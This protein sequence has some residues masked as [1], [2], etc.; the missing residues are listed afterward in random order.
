MAPEG[1]R[2]AAST[3]RLNRLRRKRSFLK[4]IHDRV[5]NATWANTAVNTFSDTTAKG[6]VLIFNQ[7]CHGVVS[8]FVQDRDQFIG[9]FHE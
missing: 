6:T 5:S 3:A 4:T 2:P 7:F 1:S 8:Y 9:G